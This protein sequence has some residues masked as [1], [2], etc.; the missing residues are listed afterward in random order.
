MSLS[1]GRFGARFTRSVGVFCLCT[2][3]STILAGCSGPASEYKLSTVLP[4]STVPGGT[5]VAYG[6]FPS[7]VQLFIDGEPVDYKT[8]TS[9]LEFVVPDQ[10]IAGLHVLRIQA[11][12][13]SLHGSLSVIPRIDAIVVDGRTVSVV[14]AGWPSDP[15]PDAPVH[16][17]LGGYAVTPELS[18][19]RLK[20]QL[21]D[22]LPNG[23]L[24]ASVQVGG[25][26]SDPYLLFREA[27]AVAGTVVF[28]G[29]TAVQAPINLQSAD[30]RPEPVPNALVVRHEPGALSTIVVPSARL[31]IRSLAPA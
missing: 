7:M 4:A 20:A 12:Q 6:S 22:V 14:G 5:V 25:W 11:D 23:S 24:V 27:G 17:E 31:P 16:L 29:P 13:V 3:L 28:T 15:S 9:G 8:V 10:T 21:N 2:C 30:Q 19:G 26:I 1:A 18:P